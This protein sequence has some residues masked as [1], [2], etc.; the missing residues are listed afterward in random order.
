MVLEKALKKLRTAFLCSLILVLLVVSSVVAQPE[1]IISKAKDPLGQDISGDQQIVRVRSKSR[2]LIV[3]VTDKQGRPKSQV[4]VYFSLKGEPLSNLTEDEKAKLLLP[5]VTSDAQG[6]ARSEILLGKNVGEYYVETS[7]GES[8]SEVIFRTIGLA[9]HWE[10]SIFLAIFGGMALFLFGLGFSSRG[11]QKAAGARLRKVLWNLTTHRLL[12]VLVG[13]GVTTIIQ[14]STATTVMLVSFANAGLMVLRQTLGVILGADI[15]TTLTVQ[16]IAFKLSDYALLIVVFGFLLMLVM[17]RRPSRYVGQILFGFGLIFYGMKIMSDGL[18]PLKLFPNFIT[19]IGESGKNPFWGILVAMLFSA[20]VHSSAATIGIVLTLSFQNLINL[21][22]AIP[23]IFGAN[24]GTCFSALLASLNSST[25]AKRVAWAHTLFKVMM[26]L[27]FLPF[28]NQ[29]ATLIENST[30]LLPRQIANAHTL[31][32]LAG[33]LLFLPLL[34]L[35]TKLIV[36]LVPEQK[37][38]EARFGPQYLEQRVLSLPSLALGQAKREVLRTADITGWM[39]K[40][41]FEVFKK[42]DKSLCEKIVSEDDKVDTLE[43][44][45]TLYLTKISTEELSEEQSKRTHELLYIVDNLEHIADVISKSLMVYAQKKISSGFYFS[46]EGFEEIKRLHQETILS[47]EIAISAIANNDYQLASEVI[48]RKEE[49]LNLKRQLHD[50]HLHRLQQ[51]LKESLETSTVHLDLLS[52]LE[53]INFLTA[54]ICEAML[55]G[56]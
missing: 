24:I 27:I 32:N 5:R 52:D 13:V 26:V 14:S 28:V 44:A 37:R 34:S 4:P 33:A 8:R 55:E 45:I 29:F 31:F 22:T 46:E 54:E 53:R 30:P 25:E 42:N 7:L 15:G 23:L 40:E 9:K 3:L 19:T 47:F 6:Y 41:T 35:Y 50:A 38:G 36:Q 11:M 21:Q 12:G 20:L 2:P 10:F 56:K 49:I 43:E 1:I 16:V 17:G 18:S 39:L 48:R 51:G